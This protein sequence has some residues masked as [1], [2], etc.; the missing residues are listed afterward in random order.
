MRLDIYQRETARIA[1]EQTALL[2]EARRKLRLGLRLSPL[3]QAGVLHAMQVLIENAIGKAKKM[4]KTANA[5]VPVSA[6]EAFSDLVRLGLIDAMKLDQWNRIVGI[7][8]RIV[9][10]YINLDINLVNGIVQE[11]G[12]QFIADFLGHWEA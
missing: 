5:P 12:Y 9:H 1:Q 11:G 7:R 4:L 10:D 2:D 6:Y 8:N 3:E